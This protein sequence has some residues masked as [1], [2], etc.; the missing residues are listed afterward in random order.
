M[1]LGT[2][3][4]AMEQI[5]RWTDGRDPVPQEILDKLASIQKLPKK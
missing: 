2:G 5:Q 4:A 1:L 3:K